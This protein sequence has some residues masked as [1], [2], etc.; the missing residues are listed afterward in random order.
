M[1]REN[2]ADDLTVHKAVKNS[3]T[4]FLHVFKAD[5]FKVIVD[6]S[7]DFPKRMDS[8]YMITSTA[9]GMKRKHNVLTT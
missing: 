5:V 4:R 1:K 3:S 8:D 7:C 6:F 2:E 9:E